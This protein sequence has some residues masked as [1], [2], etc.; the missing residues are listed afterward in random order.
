MDYNQLETL[1]KKYW[2]CETSLEE[3]ERLREWFRTHEV[4]E[5]FRETARLFSYFDEQKQK[6]TGEHFDKQ[7]VKK[8][9]SP[10][11]KTVSL[12]QTGLRIAAGIAVV[13]AAIFFVR[14]EIQDKPDMAAIE[15]P[16]KALEETKKALML[17]SKGF[18]TAEEQAKKINV[19]NE[20]EDKVKEKKSL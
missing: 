16:Q 14:E 7:I 20:A 15:D 13:A 5:R 4:P 9:H 11:G 1:I 18:S 8:L 17:I 19:L 6:A 3:E 2:D 10:K 12:W